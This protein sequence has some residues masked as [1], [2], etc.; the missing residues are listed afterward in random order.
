MDRPGPAER[1]R[2]E[3][4]AAVRAFLAGRCKLVEIDDVAGDDELFASGILDSLAFAELVTFVDQELGLRPADDE[5]VTMESFGSID[6]IVER[7]VAGGPARPPGTPEHYSVATQSV[8]SSRPGIDRFMT[9]KD[10]TITPAVSLTILAV[11]ALVVM[12]IRRFLSMGLIE[13]LI[14]FWLVQEWASFSVLWLIRRLWPF[15]PGVYPADHPVRYR[16]NLYGFISFF[17]LYVSTY[18]MPPPLLRKTLCRLLGA[19]FEPGIVSI[20]GQVSDPHLLEVGRGAMI[21]F[22][23]LLLSHALTRHGGRD[24]LVLGRIKIGRGAMIGARCIIMPDVVIGDGATLNVGSTVAMGTR[25]GANE[26]WGGTP[27]VR[28]SG[29]P[30]RSTDEQTS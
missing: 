26:V 10:M 16:W 30:E 6:L 2:D 13:T 21:G 17:N 3:V 20:S 24:V 18:F 25:I 5:E 15:R 29:P 12:G 28:L 27:A 14:L 7:V 8:A 19:K 4:E 23:A 11:A 9:W 22:D 1:T